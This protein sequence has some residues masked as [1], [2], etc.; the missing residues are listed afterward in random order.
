M[1]TG[2]ETTFVV[3]R[4]F[5][6]KLPYPYSECR[7]DLRTSTIDSVDSDLYRAFYAR[8]QTVYRQLYCYRYAYR[9]NTYLKCDCLVELRDVPGVTNVCNSAEDLD[10]DSESWHEFLNHEFY[11][12][13]DEICHLEC[14]TAYFDYD[15]TMKFP[16]DTH[17]RSLIRNHPYLIRTLQMNENVAIEDVKD[18]VVRVNVYYRD[19]GYSEL[20]EI[21]TF[22]YTDLIGTT[23]G[24]LG[25]FLG[26]S[27]INFVEIIEVIV[28]V[29]ILKVKLKSSNSVLLNNL[30][31]IS[32]TNK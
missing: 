21:A 11:G 1:K 10:C 6:N 26:V 24:L 12:K 13:F 20:E 29:C 17:V 32:K 27:L 31:L 2:T 3:S 5:V 15:M 16:T 30:I 4:N 19:I 18:R 23:G 22:T 14:N 8:N 9:I 28:E 25:L 7:L